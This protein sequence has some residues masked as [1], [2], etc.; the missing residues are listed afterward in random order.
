MYAIPHVTDIELGYLKR[1][2]Y[3]H[4]F[5]EVLDENIYKENLEAYLYVSVTLGEHHASVDKIHADMVGI[6][7]RKECY[8]ALGEMD[9]TRTIFPPRQRK[10][11]SVVVEKG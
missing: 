4:S 5:R 11:R 9:Q 10:V 1:L 7:N 8:D 6:D 3:V 2:E